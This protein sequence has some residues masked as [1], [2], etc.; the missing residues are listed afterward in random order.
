MVKL[1]WLVYRVVENF[2]MHNSVM[3]EQTYRITITY[4]QYCAIMKMIC[5]NCPE[6]TKPLLFVAQYK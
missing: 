4:K 6:Y 5:M 2:T 3:D 1:D